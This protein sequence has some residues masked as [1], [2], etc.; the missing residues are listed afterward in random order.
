MMLTEMITEVQKRVYE[1]RINKD[2]ELANDISFMLKEG[3]ISEDQATYLFNNK[4]GS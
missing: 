3:L 2:V 1:Y 4:H